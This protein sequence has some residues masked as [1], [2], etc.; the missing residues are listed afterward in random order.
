MQLSEC[1]FVGLKIA[2]VSQCYLTEDSYTQEAV[3]QKNVFVSKT[4][5]IPRYISCE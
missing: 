4:D 3:Q 2:F 5:P 1:V